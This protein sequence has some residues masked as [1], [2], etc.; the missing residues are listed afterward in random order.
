MLWALWQSPSRPPQFLQ[1]RCT[2]L[3]ESPK[4]SPQPRGEG[5]RT[6]LRDRLGNR[7]TES[8]LQA[9][10]GSVKP[11]TLSPHLLLLAVDR[12]SQR[13]TQ[14]PGAALLASSDTPPSAPHV[15]CT[16]ATPQAH[17]DLTAQSQHPLFQSPFHPALSLPAPVPW[18]HTGISKSMLA[19]AIHLFYEAVVWILAGRPS[20]L[21]AVRFGRERERSVWPGTLLGFVQCQLGLS[22]RVSLLLFFFSGRKK[23][24]DVFCLLKESL[25]KILQASILEWTAISSSRG[26]SQPRD[27]TRVS[28]ISCPRERQFKTQSAFLGVDIKDIGVTAD[29]WVSR[30]GLSCSSCVVRVQ[31]AICEG[32][33]REK[34]VVGR[35][36]DLGHPSFL[37]CAHSCKVGDPSLHT[38]ENLLV[39]LRKVCLWPALGKGG[40]CKNRPWTPNRGTGLFCSTP[41]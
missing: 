8:N 30:R 27:R 22:A 7:S 25:K 24:W 2:C 29:M 17:R 39:H 18:G 26:S 33:R 1:Q 20:V 37:G 36:R 41:C 23:N 6:R 4:A 10:R 3:H 40:G 21:E 13:P 15:L 5:L 9:S 14:F 35:Q 12:P 19:R 32:G 11:G 16:H 31:T 38:H 34:D 28:Q